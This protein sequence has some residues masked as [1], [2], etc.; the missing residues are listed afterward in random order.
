MP[1]IGTWEKQRTKLAPS[2]PIVIVRHV[3]YVAF[4]ENKN[5]L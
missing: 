3:L 5:A 4:I 1:H 2:Q